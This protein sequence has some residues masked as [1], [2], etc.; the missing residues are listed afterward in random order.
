MLGKSLCLQSRADFVNIYSMVNG[1][2]AERDG[3]RL[4]R[5]TPLTLPEETYSYLQ[6]HFP[7]H[8][9]FK[10]RVGSVG[11]VGYRETQELFQQSNTM[12]H[13]TLEKVLRY[14]LKA[15]CSSA[16]KPKTI[17]V[18]DLTY[19]ASETH[20]NPKISVMLDDTEGFLMDERERYLARLC[21][22]GGLT[23]PEIEYVPDMAIGIANIKAD[24]ADKQSGALRV[25]GVY[26][27]DSFVFEHVTSSP[28]LGS[29]MRARA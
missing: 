3:F 2:P 17:P 10:S 5:L 1:N 29:L 24:S 9:L 23:L 22:L 28:S 25:I 26:L 12:D 15:G 19:K 14:T 20:R 13:F 16:K 7:D 11:I 6:K 27:P 18:K 4:R 21:R 8:N